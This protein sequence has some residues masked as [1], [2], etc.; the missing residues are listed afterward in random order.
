MKFRYLLEV[1]FATV[2]A[3]GSNAAT[4][5]QAAR[6]PQSEK[7]PQRYEE[8]IVVTAERDLENVRDVGS[9]VSVITRDEISASGAVWLVDVLQFAPGVNV[10]RSGPSGSI[11]QLF[12]R[13]TNTGHTLFLIDGVKVNAPTT[14]SY[15]ISAM[16]LSADQIDRIEI[17]RGPQSSLYGSQAVGGV[18]NVITRAGSGAG[19]WGAE[20]DGGSFGTGRFHTWGMGQVADVSLIGG[21]SYFDSAGFSSANARNGNTETDGHRNLSYNA[22]ADYRSSSGVVLRG[23]LRGFDAELAYD[24]FDFSAGPVDSLVN[25]QTSR[26]TVYGGAIGR[27]GERFSSNVEISF[28]DADL[29]TETPEDFF[30]G[31][32]LDSSIREI[33][34][35]NDLA[36]PGG[37]HLVTGLEYRRE[38][39]RS[40]SRGGGFASGFEE[41][42]EVVGIYVQDRIRLGRRARVTAAARYEDH[43][44]FGGKW[45][46]RGT[47]TFDAGRLVRL[48]GSFG[49]GFKAPTLNDLYFPGFANPDL[50][51]EESSGLDAGLDVVV[52]AARSRV[53]AVFFYNEIRHLI[54]FDFVSGRPENIG[55]VTTTGVEISGEA[56]LGGGVTAA[57]AYTY[58]QATPAE[59]EDQLIRRPR[60]Q[61]GIQLTLQPTPALRLWG[62]LRVKGE[63]FDNG[64]RGREILEGFG[65]FNL[66]IDY[67]LIDEVLGFGTAGLSG[68]FGA[69]VTLSR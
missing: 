11:T 6:P 5:Q 10:V 46:G 7:E 32:E 62:E 29:A 2:V 66:A 39:A 47:L 33:D 64:A 13:G 14:G 57:A 15:D 36:L 61:G 50:R 16:Q 23:F 67:R 20:G 42:V 12:L 40:S 1:V 8:R 28:S 56:A 65:V 25:V 52:P 59:S 18:I 54:E 45:T 53:N 49:S 34:W 17:V 41:R 38:Q 21:V 55:D 60:H 3:V 22:R 19:S 44:A 24:G 35:Q 27:D 68:Y 9:S 37:Q 43:S 69:T 31:F 63:S 48:H 58:T 30:T 51:P 4:A 26:E